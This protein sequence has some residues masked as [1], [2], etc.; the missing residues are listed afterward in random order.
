MRE[1]GGDL[2]VGLV[3]TALEELRVEAEEDGHALA[4]AVS[5]ELGFDAGA[6]PG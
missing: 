1:A 4:G 5:D 6:E 2:G 3:V